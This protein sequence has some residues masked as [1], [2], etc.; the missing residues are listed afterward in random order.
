M[1]TKF[2]NIII[3]F[4][5]III[6]FL[7]YNYRWTGKNGHNIQT[8]I[9]S[10]GK[11]YYAYLPAIFIN[12]NLHDLNSN[13]IYTN[14]YKGNNII[15][16]HAGVALL[17]APFFLIAHIFAL[18][19]N[20]EPDGFSIPYQVL[21]SLSALCYLAVGL[22]M[23]FR[24]LLLFKLMRKSAL[25]ATLIILFGSNLLYYSVYAGSMAHVYSFFLISTFSYFTKKMLISFQNRHLIILGIITGLI[26]LVR[27]SNGIV[28]LLPFVLS[29]GQTQ[30]KTFIYNLKQ[31]LKHISI[32]I[33]ASFCIISIQFLLWYWQ[34][35]SFLIWSYKSEGFYLTN[36][37]IFNV[38]FSYRKG[39]FIYTPILLFSLIGLIL[40]YKQN[41]FQF[42]TIS[43]FLLLLVYIISS[44]WNWYYGD[45][46]GHRAFIDYLVIFA[47]F[48]GLLLDKL[49]STIYKAI[50]GLV[51]SC[52]I[53][54]NMIQ[55]YQYY[56]G[57]MDHFNMNRDKYH[58]IFLKTSDEYINKLGGNMDIQP[59]NIT[60]FTL[61]NSVA[62][63]FDEMEYCPLYV[64]RSCV[65]KEETDQSLNQA[66]SY[67]QNEFGLSYTV[68]I[69]SSFLNHGIT[70]VESSLRRKETSRNS[71]SDAL[72]IIAINDNCD[73]NFYYY[74]FKLNDVPDQPVNEWK[75]YNYAFI[76][77]ELKSLDDKIKIY[78]WNINNQSFLIDDFSMNFYQ[79]RS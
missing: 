57:I 77:P 62:V 70:Y 73:S 29:D 56:S 75:Y 18:S 54:L 38:L 43:G 55:S 78:I 47:L 21:I 67:D 4:S 2:Q 30:I 17:Q 40:H 36:P 60:E 68:P 35:G 66:F 26:I 42:I 5:L 39:L 10:D 8:V 64:N 71:S 34:S 1:S 72:F 20:Y 3:S 12:N 53:L 7:S 46:Y 52:C 51:I 48:L 44:W 32:S 24:F 33:L 74:K 16:Y 28:I 58:Y 13:P 49:N 25:F 65:V 69:D 76:I 41:K 45:S 59:Y 79:R 50:A 23:L 14:N 31:N 61:V 63:D 19:T 37:Q 11:G 27:P 15:K 22:I 6:L 9:S